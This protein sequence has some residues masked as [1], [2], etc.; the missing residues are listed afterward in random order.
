M[1]FRRLKDLAGSVALLALVAVPLPAQETRFEHSIDSQ[2]PEEG[3][4]FTVQ[5]PVS[6]SS[7]SEFAYPVLYLLDGEVNLD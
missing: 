6:Y 2:Y 4:P 7:N 1:D 5:L 3:R